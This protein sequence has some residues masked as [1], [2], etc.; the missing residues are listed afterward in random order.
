[1]TF[2]LAG[3]GGT[4]M[5]RSIALP[6][7]RC[8]LRKKICNERSIAYGNHVHYTRSTNA[9]S[10]N[11]RIR[12]YGYLCNDTCNMRNYLLSMEIGLV[13]SKTVLAGEDLATFVTDHLGAPFMSY[14]HV[15]GQSF[16]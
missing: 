10:R 12:Y 14:I 9:R 6:W 1:M 15:I 5:R 7:K 3:S 2:T 13:H 11:N 4:Y 8:K 16:S